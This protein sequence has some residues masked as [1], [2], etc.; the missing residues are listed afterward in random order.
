M[1]SGSAARREPSAAALVARISLLWFGL[2]DLAVCALLAGTAWHYYQHGYHNPIRR[3]AGDL[4]AEYA[5]C[6]GDRAE[7]ARHFAVDVSEHGRANAFLLLTDPA[8][9]EVLAECASPAILARM[10]EEAAKPGGQRYHI[11]ESH[12]EGLHG[13]VD[14]HVRTFPLPDG[15]VLSVGWNAIE[16]RRHLM[17]QCGVMGAWLLLSLGAVVVHGLSLGRRLAVPLGRLAEASGRIAAG[18]WSARVPVGGGVREISELQRAFN[19]MATE[20][21]RT[22]DELRTL[23]DDLAHDLRTPLT[24]LRVAAETDAT[25]TPAARPLAETVAEETAGMLDITNT[26]LEISRAGRRVDGAPPDHTEDLAALARRAAELY[27]AVADEAGLVLR[28]GDIPAQPVPVTAARSALQRILGNLLDNAVKYTPRGG[29]ITVSV[30]SDPPTLAVANTGPGI[31]PE[32]VPHVFDRFWRGEKSRG[33]PGHGLG[34]ALVKALAE[35]SGAAVECHSDPGVR[36]LFAV[37]FPPPPA[38]C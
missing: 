35:S 10:R 6:D 12:V 18:D 21:E 9:R 13:R 7:M 4:A 33:G 5:S 17:R 38:A 11:R 30:T 25:G 27:A 26:V 22:L 36:T 1:C 37:R 32:A 2:L 3:L 8:G 23:A 29:E 19:G 34:L 28:L 31:A 14:I 15:C 20:N 16:G 24:R